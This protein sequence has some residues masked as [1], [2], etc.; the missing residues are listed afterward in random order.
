MII[1]TGQRTDIPAFYSKWFINRIKEGFVLVRNPYYPS[2]VN[3][4]SLLPHDV[5]IIGFCT[6]N[7]KPMFKY[8]DYLKPYKQFWYISITGFGKDLEPNV[9]PI[10]EV[11]ESF[12]YLSN[13][14]GKKNIAWRY[15]PIIINDK[16]NIEYHIKTFD[17]IACKLKDYTL[18]ATY[19]FLDLYDKLKK[20]EPFLK[21][22]SKEDK[23][24]I[25]K[26]FKKIADK[27]NLE[28]RL[29]SSDKYLKEYG[30]DVDGC[31][32]ISDYENSIGKKIKLKN[33]SLARGSYC[34]CYLSHDI[35][36]YNS[37]P[38]LCKYCYAN[39]NKDEVLMNIKKH[40]DY[41]PFLI[42]DLNK[43]DMIIESKNDVII[44]DDD[45]T[46]F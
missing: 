37:C 40:S 2:R 4:Y 20:N 9:P 32:R 36:S 46:L 10:D 44:L 14:V 8:L 38:H 6:K 31:M 23:I 45:L 33:H 26:E 7:P 43:D 24:Y 42:G 15:T 13:I 22:V 41:S 39:K 28:L 3:K 27:Y 1:N 25:T 5:T 16:Y 18:L 35:G 34:A 17:Y 12:K 21:E 30:V 19:G 11:I 29:C